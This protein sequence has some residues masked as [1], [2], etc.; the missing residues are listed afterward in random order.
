MVPL[1]SSATWPISSPYVS[2]V[3]SINIARSTSCVSNVIRGPEAPT[4]LLLYLDPRW[5]ATLVSGRNGHQ[6]VRLSM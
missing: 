4:M 5:N 1:G 6:T 2:C 3:G